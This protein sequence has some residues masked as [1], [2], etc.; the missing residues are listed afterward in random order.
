MC[1]RVCEGMY[2]IGGSII[3]TT[4]YPPHGICTDILDRVQ[5]RPL[6]TGLYEWLYLL[7]CYVTTLVYK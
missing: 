2:L 4:P 7:E 5:S 3:C 1:V 6:W